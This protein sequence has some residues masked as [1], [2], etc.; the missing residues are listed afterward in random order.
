M[1]SKRFNVSQKYASTGFTLLEVM[2]A[3]VIFSICA[4]TLIQHSG[5]SVRQLQQLETRTFA[6]WIAENE[7]Q[8]LRLQGFPATGKSSREINYAKR[9][10]QMQQQVS[11]TN[12]PELRKVEIAV[13]PLKEPQDRYQLT[14]FLGKH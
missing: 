13:H 8:R 5:R 7:L 1:I 4:A 9:Q 14:G 6:N 11:V 2:V 10:W 3:L 12:N